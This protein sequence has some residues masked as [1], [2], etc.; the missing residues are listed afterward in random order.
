M[1]D[2]LPDF[3]KIAKALPLKI[4]SKNFDHK[5]YAK[6]KIIPLLLGPYDK[7]SLKQMQKVKDLLISNGYEN[8]TLLCDLKTESTFE[9][10]L[11]AKY[12]HALNVSKEEGFFLIPLFYFPNRRQQKYKLGHHS[13]LI[14]LSLT[15]DRQLILSTG[16][17]FHENT[18]ISHHKRVF[19]NRF[20]IKAPKDYEKSVLKHIEKL[21]PMIEM[22]MMTSEEQKSFYTIGSLLK[23]RGGNNDKL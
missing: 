13:E 1:S 15:K 8:A 5:K 14:H 19:P 17:F 9:D 7:R 23:E 4:D 11:D 18:E 10:E 16:I 6:T 21:C 12:I 3:I 2:S 20:L 22:E